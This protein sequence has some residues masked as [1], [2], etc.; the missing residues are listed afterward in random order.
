MKGSR[1][2]PHPG[3]HFSF[4][5]SPTLYDRLLKGGK[6][7]KNGE[8]LDNSGRNNKVWPLHCFSFKYYFSN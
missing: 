7:K 8:E 5:T 3:C 2:L 4:D 1:F 6:N